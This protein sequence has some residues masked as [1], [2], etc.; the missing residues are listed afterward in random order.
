MSQITVW[1][2]QHEKVLDELE[3][4]G[5]YRAKKEYIIKDLEEHANLVLET[6]DWLV[7]HSPDAANKPEGVTYPVWVSFQQEATMLPSP[8]TVILQL[9]V[10]SHMVT[11]VN[12]AKWGAILNYSYIPLD[13]QDAHRHQQLLE[14]YGVS[15]PQAY[16]TQFYPQIKREIIGSWDRLFDPEVHLGND[17]EY[18]LLWE[19]QKEWIVNVMR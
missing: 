1:T 3:Q 8:G 13:Q 5:R 15:D 4:T 11:P 17:L 12:I 7:K 6:Y 2:K 9:S 18:G 10:D 19:V 14:A 16:M